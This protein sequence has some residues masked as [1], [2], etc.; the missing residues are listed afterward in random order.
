MLASLS[1]F[2]TCVQGCVLNNFLTS[3]LALIQSTDLATVMKNKPENTVQQLFLL[4]LLY[5]LVHL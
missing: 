2:L 3:I 4:C 5:A 1:N